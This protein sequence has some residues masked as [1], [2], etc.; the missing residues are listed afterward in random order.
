MYIASIKLEFP[1]EIGDKVLPS[2]SRKWENVSPP[3]TC[4]KLEDL[5]V[6]AEASKCYCKNSHFHESTI[7]LLSFLSKTEHYV[8]VS[9]KKK[10]SRNE[11]IILRIISTETEI[12]ISVCYSFKK[13]NSI[14]SDHKCNRCRLCIS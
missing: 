6:S 11:F 5:T 13:N 3:K 10:K 14:S 4:E 8:V 12:Q 7:Q 2:T 1:E 9:Q